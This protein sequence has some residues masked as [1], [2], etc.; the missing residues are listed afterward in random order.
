MSFQLFLGPK[1]SNSRSDVAASLMQKS[2]DPAGQQN[3]FYHVLPLC[4]F[5]EMVEAKG[6]P[7]SRI[8]KILDDVREYENLGTFH[9][10]QPGQRPTTQTKKSEDMFKHKRSQPSLYFSPCHGESGD[11]CW[12]CLLRA[13]VL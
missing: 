8:V 13:G 1:G 6:T 5:L 12:L 9:P 2:F 3:Q 11:V 7:K 4:R 10:P